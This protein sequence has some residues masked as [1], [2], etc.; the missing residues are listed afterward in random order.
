MV[1]QADDAGEVSYEA[2][3]GAPGTVWRDWLVRVLPG[4]ARRRTQPWEPLS[5]TRVSPDG[6]D[7]A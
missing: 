7:R 5:A 2:V 4:S 6:T 3:D 1:L